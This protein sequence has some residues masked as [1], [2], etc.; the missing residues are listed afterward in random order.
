MA[1]GMIMKIKIATNRPFA[2]N[3]VLNF[4]PRRY[5]PY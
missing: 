2:V 4:D 3:Y 1:R 5:P